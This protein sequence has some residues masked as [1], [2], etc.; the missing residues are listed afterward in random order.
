MGVVATHRGR[1]DLLDSASFPSRPQP[2]HYWSTG[3][4]T[5][6]HDVEAVLA[7]AALGC[8]AVSHTPTYDQLRGERINAGV[9]ASE[10][11]PYQV[12]HPAKHRRRDDAPAAAAVGGFSPE[13]G[14][15]LAEGWSWFGTGQ[16]VRVGPANTTRPAHC[17]AGTHRRGQTPAADQ[18]AACGQQQPSVQALRAL[19]PP[20]A[21]A[22]AGQQQTVGASRDAEADALYMMTVS[23]LANE[24]ARRVTGY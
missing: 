3:S 22:R 11:D 15:D 21:H 5:Y 10:A 9:P 12:G 18:Q 16:P 13:P 4:S 19:L 8:R 1:A 2:L 6:P 7:A 14:A 17:S 24:P 20:P 23:P